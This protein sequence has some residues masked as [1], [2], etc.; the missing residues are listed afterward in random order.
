MNKS[1]DRQ[2]DKHTTRS[3]VCLT[4]AHRYKVAK[5]AKTYRIT[6]GEVIEVMLDQLNLD[7]LGPHF[8]TKRKFKESV[9]LTQASVIKK[10]KGATAEQLAEIARILE[11]GSQSNVVVAVQR[12]GQAA[13]K[14]CKYESSSGSRAA[15]NG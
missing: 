11:R 1:T 7:V 8:Q 3:A 15:S 13:V 10:F 6:R 4:E 5:I 12:P 9:R 2:K 14:I